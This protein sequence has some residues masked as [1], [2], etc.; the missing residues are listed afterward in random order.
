MML[1]EIDHK[2]HDLH[3]QI[4]LVTIYNDEDATMIITI[5]R[6]PGQAQLILII[7]RS[8]ILSL[9]YFLLSSIMIIIYRVGVA[10]GMVRLG[11]AKVGLSHLQTSGA[12]QPH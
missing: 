2:D 11:L 1:L 3:H 4:Q 5:S 6:Q 9:S 10:I 12:S 8:A 7:I